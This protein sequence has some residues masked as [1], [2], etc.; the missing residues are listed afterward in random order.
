MYVPL[1]LASEYGG[2]E[3][4]GIVGEVAIP[5]ARA[6]P[7]APTDAAKHTIA[8]PMRFTSRLS[9]TKPSETPAVGAVQLVCDRCNSLRF[10]D[11]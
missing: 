3:A 11:V 9:N 7:H 6:H 2:L 4:A 8:I 10:D 1:M 5:P